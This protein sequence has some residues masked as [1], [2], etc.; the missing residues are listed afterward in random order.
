MSVPFKLCGTSPSSPNCHQL[1]NHIFLNL[2]DG[3]KPLPFQSWEKPGVAGHKIWVVGRLI[4]LG[5]LMFRQKAL[6]EM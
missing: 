6:H 2:I 3:L 4:H 1:T 5:D